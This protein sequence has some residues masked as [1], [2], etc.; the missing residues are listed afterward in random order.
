MG[1]RA[2][3]SS[4]VNTSAEA[5]RTKEILEQLQNA[6]PAGAVVFAG[7][8]LAGERT[9]RDAAKGTGFG[10]SEFPANNCGEFGILVPV[11]EPTPDEQP[12][13]IDL[14]NFAVTMKDHF[15]VLFQLLGDE[16]KI[17]IALRSAA[18]VVA[19]AFSGG[20]GELRQIHRG[21]TSPPGEDLLLVGERLKDAIRRNGNFDFGDDGVVGGDGLRLGCGHWRAPKYAWIF[22]FGK[23]GRSLAAPALRGRLSSWRVSWTR[24]SGSGRASDR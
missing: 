5:S 10:G 12:R 11:G 14:E 18:V 16:A 9:V 6:L 4:C 15:P 20:H 13:R 19:S 3:D 1:D 17:L 22:C 8:G 23:P 24:R 7:F 2:S 21:L